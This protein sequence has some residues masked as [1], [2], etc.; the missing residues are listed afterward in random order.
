MATELL[1]I[2]VTLHLSKDAEVKLTERAA[3]V[4]IPL[5]EYLSTLVESVVESPRTLAEISGAL[6]AVS[7]QRND[8]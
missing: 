3:A 7:R 1:E 2:P 5:G 8:G 4:G 6:S